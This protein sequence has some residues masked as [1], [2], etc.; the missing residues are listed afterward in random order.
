GASTLIGIGASSIGKNIHGYVQNIADLRLYHQSLE[1]NVLP[2]SK[3]F[4]LTSQDRIHGD[5]ISEIMCYMA[6]DLAQI[7][8]KHGLKADY[9]T[10]CLERLTPLLVQDMVS[11]SGQFLVVRHP[12]M[13]RLVARCF[14]PMAP[15]TPLQNRH[16]HA[17]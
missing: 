14:D 1:N 5:V 8:R 2:V 15:D 3:G 16:T 4:L 7:S 11:L 12:H 13:A 6:V 17:I 10:S 9:F